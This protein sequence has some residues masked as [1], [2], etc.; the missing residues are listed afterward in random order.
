MLNRVIT[1]AMELLSH[2]QH[3]AQFVLSNG[4]GDGL[5]TVNKPL[6]NPSARGQSSHPK[7]AKQINPFKAKS[8][9]K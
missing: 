6:R 7:C 2:A 8:S 9:I 5:P 1:G 4:D 3:K